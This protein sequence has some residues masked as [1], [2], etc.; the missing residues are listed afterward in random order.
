MSKR[1]ILYLIFTF[2]IMTVCWGTC[3]ICSFSGYVLSEHPVLYLPYILGGLSPTVASFLVV[4]TEGGHY[5]K[6]WLKSTFDF[7]HGFYAYM[8]P[9][10]LTAVFFISLCLLS[11]FDDGAPWFSIIFMVPMMLFCGGLEEAGWRGVLQPELENR[12]GFTLSTLITAAIWA[13]WHLPLFFIVG[14]SQYGTSFGIFAL[15]ILGLSFALAAIRKCTGSTWLCILFH[16]L[17]NSMHG[18]CLIHENMIA[19]AVT[20]ALL[21]LVSYLLLWLNRK[22]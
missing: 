22:Y 4:R 12:F 16:C 18:I 1:C 6:V 10:F 20:A 15:N 21:V 17:V 3:L 7:N 2:L 19:S 9:V 13:I 11:G 5:I 14:V 8:L